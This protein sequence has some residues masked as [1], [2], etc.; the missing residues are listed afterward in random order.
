MG[1]TWCAFALGIIATP[2]AI[3]QSLTHI[4]Q[5]G[6]T[7]SQIAS[8][9]SVDTIDLAHANGINKIHKLK[10]GYQIFIPERLHPKLPTDLLRKD[11]LEAISFDSSPV[12][13]LMLV[14]FAGKAAPK[15]AA[16]N[17]A[18]Q[19]AKVAAKPLPK[20]AA[21]SAAP[22][23]PAANPVAKLLSPAPKKPSGGYTVVSGDNDW[24]IAR[25]FDTK[26]SLIRAANPNLD[27]TRLQI[28]Q[29]IALPNGST[30]VAA[31]SAS[32]SGIAR[33]RTRRA[34]V[35]RDAVNIRRDASAS[36]SVVT[37]VDRGTS[38]TV[39]DRAGDWYKLKFPRGTVGWVRGDMLKPMSS[40]AYVKARSSSKRQYSRKDD[41]RSRVVYSPK[42]GN[43]VVD[44]AMAM[45]GTRYRYGSASRGA[46]DCSGL[47]TQVYKKMGVKLPRTSRE[48]SKTGASVSKSELKPGDLV[49]FHTGR[50]RRVNHVGIY[51]GNG[52]FVHASSAKG[53][54]REDRLSDGYYA[55]R[56]VGA[57]RPVG[58]RAQATKSAPQKA[59]SKPAQV[60]AKSSS[61]P[62]GEHADGADDSGQN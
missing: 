54:V 13:Q 49:F 27:W 6:E 9:Y 2:A 58:G 33:I 62:I 56:F 31:K 26:P 47:T 17:P 35:A 38:V 20:V 22:A 1:R 45:L 50:S 59:A 51:K 43:A 28:G 11:A 23:K 57:R 24:V 55:S 25:K 60:A 37:K 18:K 19:A 41:S 40:S 39:L 44:N 30:K 21:K 14:S 3:G 16:S 7:L 36:S 52:V 34:V 12:A 8:R 15:T 48:Q 61:K 42:T 32:S 53:R 29:K 10:L 4:V 46:T 5:Q